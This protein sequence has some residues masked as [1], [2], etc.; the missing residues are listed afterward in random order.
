VNAEVRTSCFQRQRDQTFF[1]KVGMAV[2]ETGF[3]WNGSLKKL[4]P[5]LIA[6]KRMFTQSQHFRAQNQG[7]Q[8]ARNCEWIEYFSHVCMYV[9]LC[10]V[11]NCKCT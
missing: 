3:D 11:E 5:P 2:S 10:H 9:L 8:M 1:Q 7:C 6:T 4:K